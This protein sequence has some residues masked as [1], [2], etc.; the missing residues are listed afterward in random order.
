VNNEA[1]LKGAEIS[2]STWAIEQNNLLDLGLIEKRF[3]R[4]LSDRNILRTVNYRLTE[5]GKAIAANLLE[6]S[7]ILDSAS[8][9][10]RVGTQNSMLP[11]ILKP[12]LYTE[13]SDTNGKVLESI[14]VALEGYGVNFLED[15]RAELSSRHKVQWDKIPQQIDLLIQVLMDFFGVEGAKTIESMICAN[16][17]SRFDLHA[18]ETDDL[19]S[20]VRSIPVNS[21]TTEALAENLPPV[22]KDK[23]GV[24]STKL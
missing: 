13:D 17:G 8:I 4:S 16:I 7:R 11:N 12:R 21:K 15:V 20:L 23:K 1:I 22:I 24:L 6:I 18:R 5:R 10:I 3:T 19:Q 14:E 2:R 9:P